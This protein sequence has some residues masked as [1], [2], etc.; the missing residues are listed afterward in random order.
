MF[1]LWCIMSPVSLRQAG[2]SVS[3]IFLS[4]ASVISVISLAAPISGGLDQIHRSIRSAQVQQ[5][6]I[7]N[8]LI[9]FAT[10]ALCAELLSYRSC[11]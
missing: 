4:I 11:D 7:L 5:D 8:L 6:E 10:G 2:H 3:I 9:T 1:C